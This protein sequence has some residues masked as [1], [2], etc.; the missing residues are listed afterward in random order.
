MLEPRNLRNQPCPV[1]PTWLGTAEVSPGGAFA[2]STFGTW[3]VTYR[4]GRFGV[5]DGGAILLAGATEDASRPQLDDPAA[6]GYVTVRTDADARLEAVYR[7]D[8]WVRPW[9]RGLKITVRDGSLAP[10][11]EVT[12]VL[13]DRADGS[14][15]WRLQSFPERRH[16][17]AVLVD[18]FG[19]GEFYWLPEQPAIEIVPGPRASI[20]LVLPSCATEGQAL[21]GHVRVCDARGNPVR[22]PCGTAVIEGQAEGLPAEVDLWCGITPFGPVTFRGSSVQRLDVRSGDMAGQSNPVDVTA[23]GATELPIL[24]ADLHGQTAETVGTGTVA[25]YFDFARRKGL[26]DASAW[27][28]NDFQVTDALWREVQR[29]TAEANTPGEFVALLGYEWSGLT[30]AG[31]DHNVLFLGDDETIHRSGHWQI[32]DGGDAS[33]DRYPISELWREFAGREDVLVVSHVGGRYANLDFATEERPDL[34]EVHSH[35]GTF[36]WIAEE[37]MRHGLTVGFVGQGDDHTCRPGLSA[38]LQAMGRGFVSFDVW[39]GLTGVLARSR[40]REDIWQALRARHCYATTGRRIVMDVRAGH[41]A[42][43]GDEI[44]WPVGEPLKFTVRTAGH[45]ADIWDVQFWCDD[46][47]AHRSAWPQDAGAPWIRIEWSGVRSRSRNKV[48]DWDGRIK[49]SSGRIEA[50][51]HYAFDQAGQGVERLDEGTLGV[52]STTSGDIDGVLLRLSDAEATV[53]FGSAAGRFE[54]SAAQVSPEPLVF[55]AGGVNQRVTVSRFDPDART[56][57]AALAW[58][59]TARTVCRRAYWAKVV[60][61]DGHMAWSS[62]VFVHFGVDEAG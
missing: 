40:T 20:D 8:A 59:D 61:A 36:Q 52:R 13:G 56:R 55:D 57:E 27:Q 9:S 6:E 26:L 60:Q 18:A 24:W 41:G 58:S 17:F 45:G 42:I 15:G 10:G 3:T 62:P 33:S 34:V 23:T 2:V 21:H 51:R 16:V 46:R 38:P 54:F 44:A 43:M 29:R 25:E 14:P 1:D 28:G 7:N 35:H 39:G 32:H 12:V 30:P 47:I 4:A 5:D 31:G 19:T 22:G 48:T 50:F 49:A 37:A 53:T 11:D